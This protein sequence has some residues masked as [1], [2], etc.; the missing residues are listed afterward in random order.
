MS[1]LKDK[2]M[3]P[4][5]RLSSCCDLETSDAQSTSNA[6]YCQTQLRNFIAKGQELKTSVIGYETVAEVRTL[7]LKEKYIIYKVSV[8]A[9]GQNYV[10]DRR[11]KEFLELHEHALK[12]CPFYNFSNFPCTINF[13]K[14]K[15]LGIFTS[16]YCQNMI[17]T[18]ISAFN[19]MLE[20]LSSICS[21]L[22]DT[23]FL[24]WLELDR[25]LIVPL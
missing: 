24:Q 6:Q 18:R 17:Q 23:V 4:K 9:L 8:S 15:N 10:I 13:I 14:A 3:G 22:P 1:W 7:L 20:Q 5:P 11:Y 19:S 16:Y 25:E 2:M 21:R 12:R